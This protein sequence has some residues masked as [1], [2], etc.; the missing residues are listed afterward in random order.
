MICKEDDNHIAWQRFIPDGVIALLPLSDKLSSI[1]WSTETS[2]AKHLL[3]LSEQD[4]ID[5]VNEAFVRY[6]SKVLL[7]CNI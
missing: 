5:S 1:V 7:C 4:F 3:T 6:I 2:M